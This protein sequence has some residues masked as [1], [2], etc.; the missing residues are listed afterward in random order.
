MEELVGEIVAEHEMPVESIVPEPDGGILVRG[1]VPVHE[2]NRELGIE[3]P[4]SIERVEL[5][6]LDVGADLM[7]ARRCSGLS[8]PCRCHPHAPTSRAVLH[9]RCHLRR[10][11]HAARALVRACSLQDGS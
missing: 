6:D 4:E 2:I 3:L 5:K 11:S 7:E 10:D 1:R 8:R 9:E